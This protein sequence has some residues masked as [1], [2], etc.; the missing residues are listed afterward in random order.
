MK[1]VEDYPRTQLLRRKPAALLNSPSERTGRL[2][3][4]L[5][6]QVLNWPGWVGFQ[7]RFDSPYQQ[8]ISKLAERCPCTQLDDIFKRSCTDMQLSC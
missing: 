7:K 3:S 4:K 1:N 6:G 8:L 5:E 2:V